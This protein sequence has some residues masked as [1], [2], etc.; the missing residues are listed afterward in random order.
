M[1]GDRI[2]LGRIEQ[3]RLLVLNQLHTGGLVNAEA[4]GLLG[5]SVRQV[6]RLSRA[7]VA[8]GAAALVHGNRVWEGKR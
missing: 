5:L 8:Q 7:Y 3:R 2:Q 4:A 6:Q 1:K